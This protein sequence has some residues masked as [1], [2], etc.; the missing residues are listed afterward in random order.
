MNNFLTILKQIKSFKSN[1][2]YGICQA[3]S[4]QV[5]SGSVFGRHEAVCEFI[6]EH[7]PEYY[8]GDGLYPI[9]HPEYDCPRVG[10]EHSFKSEALDYDPLKHM[11]YKS[12]RQEIFDKMVELSHL[13]TFEPTITWVQGETLEG[14]SY[15]LEYVGEQK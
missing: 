7:F 3:I 6:E 5:D 8:S 1:H 4:M 11:A 13:F 9:I 12:R 10:Y 15:V 2:Y 14:D